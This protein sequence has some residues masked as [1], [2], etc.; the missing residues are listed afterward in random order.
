MLLHERDLVDQFEAEVA[1]G[2]LSH[3]EIPLRALD[4]PALSYFSRVNLILW[5]TQHRNH[6]PKAQPVAI[7]VSRPARSTA[8]VGSSI[9]AAQ[10]NGCEGTGELQ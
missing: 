3:Y 6:R 2:G 8:R 9:R 4:P 10:L 5:C 1:R 7:G